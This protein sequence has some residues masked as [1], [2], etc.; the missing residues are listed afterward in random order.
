MRCLQ[1]T[2]GRTT[3]CVADED[4]QSDTLPEILCGPTYVFYGYPNVETGGV[5]ER[6][7]F[8]SSAAAGGNPK[9]VGLTDERHLRS[10]AL[11]ATQP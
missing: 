9:Y 5:N 2:E 10:A 11:P 4:G 1:Q 7:S 3:R 8:L 6:P